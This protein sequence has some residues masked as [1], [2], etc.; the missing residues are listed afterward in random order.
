MYSY[1]IVKH[2]IIILQSCL[3]YR[4]FFSRLAALHSGL[5]GTMLREQI[6]SVGTMLREQS[7]SVGTMLREQIF[8]I[9]GHS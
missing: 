6:F 7:F 3:K 8:S 9:V 1:S 4:G 5:T 2:L